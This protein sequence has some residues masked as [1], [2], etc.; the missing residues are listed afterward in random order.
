M[1]LTGTG[2]D[3][4]TGLGNESQN[5]R[6]G[7]G[8]TLETFDQLWKILGVLDLN[9]ALDDRGNGKLHDLQVVGSLGSGESTRLQQELINTNE[10]KNVT[11][12]NIINW[13]DLATHHEDGTLDSL[14]EEIILFSWNVVW[15]LDADLET[16]L[17]SSR[18]DTTE[19]VETTLIGS[20]HHLGDVKHERTLSITV[21][22]TH[23]CLIVWWT[24]V[25]SLST[26][27]LGS[28][29]GWEM[30]NQHLQH[31]I[32]GWEE[33]SHDNLQESLALLLLVLSRELDVELLKESVDLILLEV[34]YGTEDSENRVQD[35]L[36]ESTLKWLAI[37]RRL[38]GPLLGVWVE[39]VVTLSKV[40][41]VSKFV[42]LCQLTQR[43]S[44]IL[45]LSTPNF[46]A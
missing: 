8:K 19:S 25:E 15:S 35:E 9:G 26:V 1:Q 33:S 16:R 43:R 14:D 36:V 29:W 17:D 38:V 22:D 30:K 27:L 42:D 39:V 45:T 23:A 41:H 44:I 32:S 11:S 18:E 3:M 4:L 31:S 6:I 5:A 10:T 28:D 20:W 37:V 13:V 21:L 24:L 12:W 7:L 34:H 46:L 40:S 2:N